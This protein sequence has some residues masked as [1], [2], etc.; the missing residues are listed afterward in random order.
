MVGEKSVYNLMQRTAVYAPFS[1][2]S[3][4]HLAEGRVRSTRTY[5]LRSKK[6]WCE[7]C[8]DRPCAYRQSNRLANVFISICHSNNSFLIYFKTKYILQIIIILLRFLIHL[9][10]NAKN[11]MRHLNDQSLLV[12]FYPEEYGVRGNRLMIT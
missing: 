11:Q 8:S 3:S 9:Q 5:F 2:M 10:T 12:Q 4:G 1:Q 6:S 7:R